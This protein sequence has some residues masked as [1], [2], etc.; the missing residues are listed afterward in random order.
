VDIDKV[1]IL[2]NSAHAFAC[3]A[4]EINQC[5]F[6]IESHSL[7][8]ASSV[9]AGLAIEFYAK[10]LSQVVVGEFERTHDLKK[11]LARLPEDVQSEL[12]IAF[13]N[14]PKD[15]LEE[16]IRRVMGESNT[17]IKT[18]FD[19]VLKNWSNVFVN[20][21][22]WF[23]NL[24]HQPSLHSYFFDELVCIFKDAISRHKST[25]AAPDI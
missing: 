17:T 2:E 7:I 19:S 1:R 12:R 9:N 23:E 24:E 10:C 15:D 16:E 8:M 14:I 3:V 4:R 11:I 25:A 18:D 13:D 5:G 21:R 6:G 22:Y 20:G